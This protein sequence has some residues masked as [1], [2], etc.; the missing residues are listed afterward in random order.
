M[1]TPSFGLAVALALT[2]CSGNS[3]TP[4]DDSDDVEMVYPPSKIGF[5]SCSD[6]LFPMPVLSI[7][8]TKDPDLFVFLGDNIYGD[9]EDMANL[10]SKYD[11]LG[12]T[13]EFQQI[14]EAAS[15]LAVWDDHDYGANDA[16]KD[17]PMKAESEQIF[18]DFWEE[19]AD[20]ERRTHEGIYHAL[21]YEGT[22][23]PT[24]QIIL[25]DTR[26]FRDDLTAN[27]GTGI[28]DY[29]PN[30][31]PS[32]TLLGDAQ[33][34]WLEA[35]LRVEADLRII[36]SSTQF[37]HSYNGFESWNN[38]PA[39]K[40]KLL[41]LIRT[42]EAEG[43]MFL[44]GDVHHAEFSQVE[45]APGYT[46]F[47]ATSSAISRFPSPAEENTQRIGNAF[48]PNNAGL[49]EIDWEAERVDISI[50]DVTDTKRLTHSFGFDEARF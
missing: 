11:V 23:G 7:L 8:A 27:D 32:L 39:E 21:L 18:L 9:T 26:Y 29:I 28:N 15:L 34:T 31:D 25:L 38:L 17:Y 41:E 3:P 20:S 46:L 13:A 35:Q 36:A 49:V 47:D 40:E 4:K 48:E 50:I 37:A 12:A 16:G 43:V 24:L 30:D 22:P 45:V 1:K 33:W 44:T 10:Q 6:T 14:K 42:T 2:A 19:P 5:G